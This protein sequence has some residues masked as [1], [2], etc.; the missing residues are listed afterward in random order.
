MKI[1][2]EKYMVESKKSS[3]TTVKI[4]IL[5]SRRDEGITEEPERNLATQFKLYKSG[6]ML[7]M[8]KEKSK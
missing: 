7:K 1:L 3:Q 5:R 8:I 6:K 2:T 4:T